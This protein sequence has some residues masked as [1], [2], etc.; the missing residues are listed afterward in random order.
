MYLLQTCEN[1]YREVSMSIGCL[2]PGSEVTS[3]PGD[4]KTTL[5]NSFLHKHRIV[6]RQ[7]TKDP[8]TEPQHDKFG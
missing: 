2:L 7:N 5:E 6:L 4:A 8:L 1:H 3:F